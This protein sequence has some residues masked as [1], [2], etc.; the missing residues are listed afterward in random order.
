MIEAQS[1]LHQ[2]PRDMELA[3]AEFRVVQDYHIKHQAYV[4]LLA[5]KAKMDWAKNGDENTRLFHQRIKARRIQNQ[6]HS[7]Y[8]TAGV[9]HDSPYGASSS[10][11]TVL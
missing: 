1:L 10:F 11:F 8:D 2:N 5:Q 6:I 9:W 4:E 7:I 3:D